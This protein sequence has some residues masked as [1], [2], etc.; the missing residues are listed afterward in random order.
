MNKVWTQTEI[1]EYLL[2]NPLSAKVHTGSLED[3]NN[4][5][6]IFFDTLSERLVGADNKGLYLSTVQFT[7][8]TKDFDNRKLMVKYIK[9]KFVCS[10]DYERSDEAEYYVAYCVTTLMMREDNG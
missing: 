1:Y 6:Y 3:M 8:A 2:G 7:V 9:D 5:D 10:I 4:E